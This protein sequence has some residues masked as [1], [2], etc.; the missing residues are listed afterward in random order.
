MRDLISACRQSR[1]TSERLALPRGRWRPPCHAQAR[2]ARRTIDGGSICAVL[3]RYNEVL[4]RHAEHCGALVRRRRT[5]P[6]LAPPGSPGPRVGD[7]PPV[8]PLWGWPILA[9][10][11]GALYLF[12]GASARRRLVDLLERPL[13]KAH[14]T[15]AAA[16]CCGSPSPSC[17]TCSS[18]PTVFD[19]G[20]MTYGLPSSC[21]SWPRLPRLWRRR[22]GL[23]VPAPAWPHDGPR[24]SGQWS[25]SARPS[26]PMVLGLGCDHHGDDDD[27]H[28]G[29]A[30]GARAG[31][32]A[33]R[34]RGALFGPSSACCWPCC[35]SFRPPPGLVW[36]AAVGTTVL[37]RRL[38]RAR[39][40]P[41]RS[42]ASCWS[43]RRCG[44][45]LANVLARP[46]RVSV[47]STEAVP[48]FLPGRWSSLCWIGLGVLRARASGRPGCGRAAWACRV[49]AE[50][51]LVGFLRRDFAAPR[52][53]TLSRGGGLTTN[54]ARRLHGNH[55]RSS[56]L[57]RQRSS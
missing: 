53:S 1:N 24:L 44:A 49:T 32:V 55:Q 18:G 47:V 21:R 50:A 14:S 4:L 8:H 41:A 52:L 36:L 45:S 15:P 39:L 29:N 27:A 2:R 11:L 6:A 30:Q 19:D 38:A 13:R 26:C 17:V 31:H 5:L 23:R 16:G 7:P 10:V 57:H 43:C 48:L 37:R 46:G 34:A 42:A 35:R 25:E 54:P 40:L 20:R 33:A 22:G 9:A 56:S 3:A 28:P 12:V 51:F